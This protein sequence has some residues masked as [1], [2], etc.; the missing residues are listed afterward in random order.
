MFEY[1]II[2][3]VINA[4][5]HENNL[6]VYTRIISFGEVKVIYEKNSIPEVSIWV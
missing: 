6:D 5:R 2:D 4:H 3:L 1:F